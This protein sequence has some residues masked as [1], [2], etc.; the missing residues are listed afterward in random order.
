MFLYLTKKI[1]VPAESTLTTLS[2]DNADGYLICGGTNKY[3]KMLKFQVQRDLDESARGIA[4]ALNITSNQS[5]NGHQDNLTMA[6]WNPVHK[7]V[8]SVDASGSVIIWIQHSTMAGGTGTWVEELVN[9]R[10]KSTVVDLQWSPDG[11]KILILYQ[12]GTVIMGSF[13]GRRL[14][15][16][17]LG[18]RMVSMQ[19]APDSRSVL[20][21]CGSDGSLYAYDAAGNFLTRSQAVGPFKLSTDGHVAVQLE[22]CSGSVKAGDM[23]CRLAILLNSGTVLLCRDGRVDGS[24]PRE[25]KTQ[26]SVSCMRWNYAGSVLAISG[27]SSGGSGDDDEK[28]LMLSLYDAFGR[29][30]RT[31]KLPGKVISAVSWERSGIRMALAVDS[32]IYIANCR[33]NYQWTYIRDS[34]AISR[35]TVVYLKETK[36]NFVVNFW[37][38]KTLSLYQKSSFSRVFC[39]ASTVD[40]CLIV[41][42]SQIESQS[43][44]ADTVLMICDALGTTL[45][46]ININYEPILGCI[47]ET[48]VVLVNEDGQ[49]VH[50]WNYQSSGDRRGANGLVADAI[51]ASKTKEMVFSINHLEVGSIASPIKW[52]PKV[53]HEPVTTQIV[54]IEAKGG[55]LL[56]ARSDGLIYHLSTRDVFHLATYDDFKDMSHASTLALNCDGS[57]C[58]VI[59]MTGV[60]RLISLK[61]FVDSPNGEHPES[62]EIIKKF[63]RKDTWSILWALDAPRR[64]AIMEKTKLYVYKDFE[65][66]EPLNSS[67][68]LCEYQSLQLT[69]VLLDELIASNPCDEMAVTMDTKVLR[70]TK[71]ILEVSLDDAMTFVSNNSHPRLWHLLGDAALLQKEYA[72]ALK[73]YVNCQD[74]AAIKFVKKVQAIDDKRVKQ[75]EVYAWLAKYSE[76]ESAYLDMERRDLALDLWR[77][78]GDYENALKVAAAN[79][80]SSIM[81]Q[82]KRET[83]EYY[84]ERQEWEK[85]SEHWSTSEQFVSLCFIRNDFD[86][87]A[88]IVDELLPSD[89]LLSLIG[90]EFQSLGMCR[91]AS[92]AYL[93]Q[94]LPQ[95]ALDSCVFLHEWGEAR[96]IATK[97][98]LSIE[99]FID[100]YVKHLTDTGQHCSLIELYYDAKFYDQCSKQLFDAGKLAWTHQKP[101][102][103]KRC[104]VL[105]AICSDKLESRSTLS[106]GNWREVVMFH[107]FLLSQRLY[108]DKRY[109]SALNCIMMCLRSIV[110]SKEHLYT[111]LALISHASGS[112]GHLKLAVMHL[113]PQLKNLSRYVLEDIPYGYLL[114]IYAAMTSGIRDVPDITVSSDLTICAA[115]G[116]LVSQGRTNSLFVCQTCGQPCTRANEWKHCPVCHIVI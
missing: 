22:W 30:L 57:I 37:N 98:N 85:A 91:M 73:A 7:K 109:D 50:I 97:Y 71:K 77:T 64:F 79:S 16:K 86:A 110:I 102:Y 94:G 58:A 69:S 68:Y 5:M 101:I 34:S 46:S 12:D 67:G 92:K 44:V 45:K 96:Y 70:D 61:S 81:Q 84:Y 103:A 29:H 27:V 114:K 65:P 108:H 9:N 18:V 6:R 14:W 82:L 40:R 32:F 88:K 43:H 72:F 87:L 10:Q 105:A 25:I 52:P 95:K 75:A 11:E 93:K 15:G 78:V 51:D 62:V 112:P 20:M 63:E 59:D 47:T 36:T 99:T 90:D 107:Y 41:A 8:A 116:D 24:S 60:T 19:W 1:G 33:P 4:G 66:E 89:S 106:N 54:A 39:I 111:S 21:A 17:E 100:D 115:T 2:W 28:T 74:Y 13:D 31:M 23:S 3:L 76:A 113:V 26:M 35:G 80:P 53:Q 42:K 49:H 83:S 104:F 56:I 38:L 48:T 55:T